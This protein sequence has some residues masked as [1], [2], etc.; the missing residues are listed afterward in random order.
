MK[1]SL[2]E[3]REVEKEIERRRQEADAQ[4]VK[5]AANLTLSEENTGVSA[6]LGGIFRRS[7]DGSVVTDSARH[8]TVRRE[9]SISDNV[10]SMRAMTLSENQNQAMHN[11]EQSNSL[12][13]PDFRRLNTTTDFEHPKWFE[14]FDASVEN[15][16]L[17]DRRRRMKCQS[18]GVYTMRMANENNPN[19]RLYLDSTLREGPEKLVTLAELTKISAAVSLR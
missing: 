2:E 9:K 3:E 10:A 19:P 14:E 8:G 17:K 12:N 7:R 4:N 11:W 15:Q 16:A 5:A 6:F 13:S 1:E 18:E